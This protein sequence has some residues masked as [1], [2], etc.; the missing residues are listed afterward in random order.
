[1]GY[2]LLGWAQLTLNQLDDAEHNLNYALIIDP[3]LAAAHFNL[4]RWYH[5]QDKLDEA[6]SSFK[7]A[8]TIDPGGPIGN[9]AAEKYNEIVVS[10]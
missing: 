4:G 2:N 8:Y 5:T 1:M 3:N 9:L 10:P 7:Q 6:K